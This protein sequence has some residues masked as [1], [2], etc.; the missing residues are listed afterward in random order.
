MMLSRTSRL[1]LF[2]GVPPSLVLVPSRPINSPVKPRQMKLSG[3]MKPGGRLKNVFL[4]IQFGKKLKKL[5]KMACF[6][7]YFWER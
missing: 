2:F 6:L 5:F 7:V 3:Q 1:E 4:T